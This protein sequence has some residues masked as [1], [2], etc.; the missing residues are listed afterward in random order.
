[1]TAISFGALITN[2][3]GETIANLKLSL[4]GEFWRSSTGSSNNVLTFGYGKI[5]GTTVNTSNFLTV[6]SNIFS[7][8]GLNINGPAPVAPSGSSNGPL[9]GNDPTNQ[10]TLTSVS[11]PLVLQAGESAFLRWEDAK[12]GSYDG[13]LA[14][15]DLTLTY[16]VD[17]ALAISS[18]TPSVGLAGN[19][20][21]IHGSNFTNGVAVAFNGTS[22]SLVSVVSSTELA[23]T[24]PAGV[25]T[26][27]ITVGE[28]AGQ[29]TST[30]AF[31]VGNFTCDLT[32]ADFG[33][34]TLGN[35]SEKNFW[36]NGGILPGDTVEMSVD[37]MDFSLSGDRS[38]WSSS[39]SIPVT[40]GSVSDY[41]GLMRFDPLS[42]GAKSTILTVSSG[43]I[44]IG[45]YTFTGTGTG[46]VQPTSFTGYGQNGQ[47]ALSWGSATNYNLVLLAKGGGSVTDAPTAS[48]IY[49]G[50][51]NFG[52][53]T[54]VG[55]STTIFVDIGATTSNAVVT[56][57]SNNTFYYF[58]VFNRDTNISAVSTGKEIRVMPFASISSNVIT[59]WNFNNSDLT[60]STG[61]GS[62]AA[63]GGVTPGFVAGATGSSD[64]AATNKAASVRGAASQFTGLQF[65]VSTAGKTG[66]KVL[67]DLAASSTA[68]KYTRFQY[69]LDATAGTPTWVDYAP[70]SADSA[71][72]T[73]VD[74]LYPLDQADYN[75]I[76]RSADL[77]GKAGVENNAKFGF[78]V[79]TANAPGT[80]IIT[81]IDG[82]AYST[83][84]TVKYDMVTVTGVDGVFN[85]AP[86]DIGLSANSIAENNSVNA[87][88]GTLSTT[89]ADAGDTFTYSLV[90]GTD[91]TDN[92]SFSIDGIS[93]KAGI[94][95][96][97]ET[98]I[99]YSVRVRATDAGGLYTEKA[100]T[101][102]V[103]DVNETPADTTAPVITLN[104]LATVTVAWGASYADS[105]ATAWDNVDS[106]VTVNTSGSVNT[107][108]PGTY[109]ITYTASDAAS[110][111]ATP[112]TRTV[113]VS[114]PS[115]TAGADGLSGL[116]RY[117][118]GAN[119][120][121][122]SV[123]K[124][125]SALDGT[126]LSITAI[127]RTNDTSLAVVGQA[128]TNLADYGTPAS[129][130]VVEGSATGIDQTGVPTGCAKQKFSVNRAGAEK[131]FLRLKA[132]L[133]P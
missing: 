8:V 113:T 122:D 126:T 74:G 25:T 79:I 42:T 108:K 90:A 92:A 18:F 132:T 2:T 6:S 14:I 43:G 33:S 117:A 93:L 48:G 67:W 76:Q 72:V 80:N 125:T 87:V 56:G 105:G 30:T 129:V 133:A 63:V 27:Y 55:S 96:D 103:T 66:V 4:K 98:K 31:V 69:T 71:G 86:T 50:N 95:F 62:I 41:I 9:D 15:D 81:R 101:V 99:S 109:T 60:A 114:A 121:N 115:E 17:T 32:S 123:T 78:R 1:T 102:T 3:T 22:A 91:S 64:L 12:D 89:D 124:P 40:S 37:S 119:G 38:V 10:V 52:G 46:L 34:V 110:N 11:I 61:S 26:G 54:A 58:K 82:T 130:G 20:V 24:V 35:T 100:F 112:V 36:I 104:G 88:V 59:Q 39:L 28:G 53:G 19:Q 47:A 44:V 118:Y 23:A 97:Y 45:K 106:S 75:L 7:L 128:V 84:G 120:P 70:S 57:L 29:V 116:L 77:S 51:T 68:S 49:T 107:A 65:A 94:A 127:V 21:T 13:G 5:N 73:P 111:A 131:K 85:T 16:D 83:T